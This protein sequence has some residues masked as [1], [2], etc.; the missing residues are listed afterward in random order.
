MI[1]LLPV[2]HGA[3]TG[4]KLGL[5]IADWASR[6]VDRT[7][8]L[9]NQESRPIFIAICFWGPDGAAENTLS[10]GWFM[11]PGG[12][13]DRYSVPVPRNGHCWLA[14]HARTA[15]HSATWEGLDA[16][17]RNFQVIMPPYGER[18]AESGRFTVL[19]SASATPEV[20]MN[21]GGVSRPQPVSGRLLRMAGDYRFTFAA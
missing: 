16:E 17:Q 21:Q 13:S 6:P 7:L 20:L 4:A 11:L 18:L 3:M 8:T 15:D 10:A 14:L 19:R 12:G 1:H 2:L 9:I 5:R